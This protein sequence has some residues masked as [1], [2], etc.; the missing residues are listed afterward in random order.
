MWSSIALAHSGVTKRSGL[1]KGCHN[2]RKKGEYHCHSKSKYSGKV[3]E[4][5]NQALKSMLP[6]GPEGGHRFN[7]KKIGLGKVIL[8]TNAKEK[9][10][11]IDNMYS[12]DL[13]PHW[14]DEDNDCQDTRAEILIRDSV[15]KVKF[16]RTKGE[17]ESKMAN[18]G[19]GW[20]HRKGA[21]VQYADG[22]AVKKPCNISHGEWVGPYSGKTFTKASDL[23]IDHIVPLA[24]AHRNGAD[25]WSRDK[26]REFSNDPDNLLA[27]EVNLSQKKSDK[28]PS[29]WRPPRKAYWCEYGKKWVKVKTKYDLRMSMDERMALVEMKKECGSG[30]RKGYIKTH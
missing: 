1:F 26:R 3:W 22:N 11:T 14:I 20:R 16:K 19:R 29:E 12:R 18:L 5:E 7:V 6:M 28:G 4:S 27:V 17:F 30:I 23:D 24:H 25:I 9:A 8:R 15:G 10:P 21:G 2:D 13:Y